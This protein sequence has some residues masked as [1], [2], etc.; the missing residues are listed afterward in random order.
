M[1]TVIIMCG[2][3][4]SGKSYTVGKI[5]E[6]YESKNIEVVVCSSD[7]FMMN[8]KGEYDF[9]PSKLVYT[10]RQCQEKFYKSLEKDNIVIIVDN[11]NVRIKDLRYYE[12]AALDKSFKTIIVESD[13]DWKDNPEYCAKINT[14]NVPYDKIKEMHN[15]LLHTRKVLETEK[16]KIYSNFEEI[17]NV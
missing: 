11:T 17:I 10:H 15:S 1:K 16:K 5:K 9:H 6:H 12:K 7:H 2:I 14:H 3:P 4:G 13:S 8:D